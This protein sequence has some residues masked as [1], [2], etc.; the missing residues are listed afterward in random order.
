M[1]PVRTCVGCRQRDLSKN[2]HRVVRIKDEFLVSDSSSGRGAWVHSSCIEKAIERKGF[3]RVLGEANLAK[4]QDQPE[5]Q[6]E[7]HAGNQM[8]TSK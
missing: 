2:L 3:Q 5:K 4:L 6:A 1:Y 7:K 8:S